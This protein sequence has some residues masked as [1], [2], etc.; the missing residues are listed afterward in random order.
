MGKNIAKYHHTSKVGCA[1]CRFN[2]VLDLRTQ[3]Y[4][5]GK[6]QHDEYVDPA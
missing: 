1:V 2:S 4:Y 6:R 5:C 3:Q